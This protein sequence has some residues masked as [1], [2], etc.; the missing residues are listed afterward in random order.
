MKLTVNQKLNV[1]EQKIKELVDFIDY[2][3]AYTNKIAYKVKYKLLN[4][5]AEI[6]TERKQP[7]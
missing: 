4:I 6:R 3:K 5:R 2:S 1:I 7:L